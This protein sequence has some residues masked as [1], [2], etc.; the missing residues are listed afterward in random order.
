MLDNKL[1]TKKNTELQ[2]LSIMASYVYSTHYVE[3][4]EKESVVVNE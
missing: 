4:K 2:H 1:K 3:T